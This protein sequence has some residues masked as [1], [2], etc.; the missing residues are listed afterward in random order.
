MACGRAR[1]FDEVRSDRVHRRDGLILGRQDVHPRSILISILAALLSAAFC[2]GGAWPAVAQRGG[3]GGG[4][5]GGMHGFGGMGG[6]GMG[7]GIGAGLA[8]GPG[9]RLLQQGAPPPAVD[10]PRPGN[11]KTVIK[12]KLEPQK[13]NPP[14]SGGG[15]AGGGG[16]NAGDSGVPPRGERRFVADEI[17][18]AFSPG[19]SSQTIDQ[20]A[21]RYNLAQLESQDLPLIGV[22]VYR[23]RIPAGRSLADVV[24]AVEDER[25][26]ASAQPNY[27]CTLQEQPASIAT[28][29]PG[30]PAQYVL[31]KLQVH[32]AHELATG[33]S[34]L[35][36][37]I[38]SEIDAAHPDLG[39]AIVKSFD[40]LGGNT[41]PHQHGT[42]IAGAIGSHGKLLG[43]APGAQLLAA[44]AFDATPGEAK[45]TSF[46][47]L[48]AL[49]WAADNDA[50]VV[51]MSFAGPVDPVLHRML[52]AA[53]D[54]GLVLVAA[55]GNVGPNSPPL[56]PAADANVIAVTATDSYDDL[57]KM[58]NRGAYVAV[59]APGVEILA[60]APAGAYQVT[61]GTSVAAAHVS[62]V[63]ALLLELK[64]SLKPKDI[65]TIL[66]SSAKKIGSGEHSDFGAGLAD[67]YQAIVAVGG[68]SV[69]NDGQAKR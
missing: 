56:Y 65:R 60:A 40:A 25:T 14:S 39:G 69:G 49:Q 7:V 50:R 55:A 45:G 33:K 59:A 51:N 2:V 57:F 27:V 30:D 24:G 4:G 34:V 1:L 41:D 42:A 63:A 12:T 13:P 18:T 48:K 28:D 37:V 31:Q 26:V 36:A 44:R 20:I 15:G 5:M 38:D 8:I 23:W 53:S 11:R 21:R 43:I 52:A 6:G 46:A 10:Q 3:M 19:T 29:A 9:S 66:M 64:P 22:T 62:G 58:A 16:N 35:I 54:K 68:K 61:T 47:I 32:E 67:A 17:I